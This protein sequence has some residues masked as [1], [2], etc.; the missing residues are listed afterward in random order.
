RA[1]S[2]VSGVLQE[3]TIDVNDFELG[4]RG[5][6]WVSADRPDA[7]EALPRLGAGPGAF[8]DVN[9]ETGF[10]SPLRVTLSGL[11]ATSKRTH[12]RKPTSDPIDLD[13]VTLSLDFNEDAAVWTQLLRPREAR[14]AL[15]AA[16]HAL[17]GSSSEAVA[18][19]KLRI[20]RR[21]A[22]LERQA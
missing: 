16:R 6:I 2:G 12:P 20:A 7:L 5:L 18:T 15:D 13:N 11:N 3:A 19:Q 22:R 14:H 17:D 4:T 21:I 9:L 1:S 10:E 8:V